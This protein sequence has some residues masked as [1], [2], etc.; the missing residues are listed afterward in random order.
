M[1]VYNVLRIFLRRILFFRLEVIGE[2]NIPGEGPVVLA[3][4][5]ISNWDP[6]I[7]GAAISKRRIYY[8]AKEEL[9]KIPV[10]ASI[11]RYLGAFPVKRGKGDRKALKWAFGILADNKLLGLFPEGTRSKTGEL[12]PFQSGA[13]MLALKGKAQVIPTFIVGSKK[14]VFGEPITEHLDL[15]TK[16]TS[17][18]IDKLNAELEG[19]VRELKAHFE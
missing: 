12:Q 14:V 18:D 16:V 1:F 5:H 7:I 4:N 10:L 3:S 8:M 6:I 17:Q 2:E 15:D 11:V 9:F 13:A 19:R